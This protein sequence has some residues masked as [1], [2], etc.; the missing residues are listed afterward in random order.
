MEISNVWMPLLGGMMLGVA[1]LALLALNGRVAG[2][3]GIL[4]GAFGAKGDRRWR[5]AFIAGLLLSGA[6]AKAMG[7][8]TFEY[9]TQSLPVILLAGFLVG[10]GTVIGGGCTSG[11]GICGNGRLSVR[12]IV[13]TGVFMAF[14]ILAAVLF[15]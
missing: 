1:S 9:A 10:L 4:S 3:S 14:G 2:I 7:A 11:H 6:V 15:H 13:A 8:L 5:W 12:S